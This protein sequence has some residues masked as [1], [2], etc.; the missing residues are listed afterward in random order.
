MLTIRIQE[1]TKIGRHS[2]QI[3]NAQDGF[4]VYE[5]IGIKNICFYKSEIFLNSKYWQEIFTQ[6]G[7]FKLLQCSAFKY[8]LTTMT[9]S[10]RHI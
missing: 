2:I 8:F 10:R 6:G 5:I 9:T 1:E 3:R 4:F 7:L